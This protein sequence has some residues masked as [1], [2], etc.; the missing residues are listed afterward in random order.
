MI[1]VWEKVNN[2]SNDNVS[3]NPTN[4]DAFGRLRISDLNTILDITHANDK[5]DFIVAEKVTGTATSV[6]DSNASHVIMT[7]NNS[8]DSVIRQSRKYCIYQ[9][10]KSLLIELTGVL[11]DSVS[12]SAVSRMGYFDASDGIFLEYNAG[13]LNIV[14]RSSASGS[15]VETR[16]PQ[17]NWNINTLLVDSSSSYVLDPTKCQI[18][19]MD[20][21]WLGVGRVRCGFVHEGKLTYVHQFVHDNITTQVYMKTANLPI[22]YEIQTLNGPGILCHICSTVMSEGGYNPVNLSFATGTGTSSKS[23]AGTEYPLIGIRIKAGKRTNIIPGQVI[24]LTS[25]NDFFQYYI[26]LYKSPASSPITDGT[27]NDVN[28][29]S[30]VQAN[31]NCTTFTT[32]GSVIISEGYYSNRNTTEINSDL[33]YAFSGYNMLTADIDGKSD[34]LVVTAVKLGGGSGVNTYAAIDW[35]EIF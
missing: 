27:W 2:I 33:T 28:I 20:F 17:V 25:S 12:S 15:I 13:I 6:Y 32:S 18:F 26:R 19:L 22:R 7:V 1:R 14:K 23:V 5:N 30:S 4:L 21:Q 10:G 34:Y 35:R 24:V 29:Y 31:V 9:P 11:I 8:G 16:V 3:F